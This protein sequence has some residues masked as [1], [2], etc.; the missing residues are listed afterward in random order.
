MET[1]A[2][3]RTGMGEEVIRLRQG[4]FPRVVSGEVHE[5]IATL[6]QVL[7]VVEA[8]SFVDLYRFLC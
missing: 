4:P 7:T 1:P 8:K 5:F 2:L 6:R 3:H